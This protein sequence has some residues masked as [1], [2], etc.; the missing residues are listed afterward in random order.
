MIIDIF[1][2]GKFS[3]YGQ[4]VI[5]YFRGNVDLTEVTGAEKTE[6]IPINPMCAA[7]PTVVNCVSK[8]AGTT[9]AIDERSII[10]ILGQNVMN[11]KIYLV[12]W[13][14]FMVL[15]SV[16]GCMIVYRSLT[17]GIPSFQ[18]MTIQSFIKS[19]D[20]RAVQAL[21]LDYEHIGNWFVLGQIGRNSTPYNFRTFLDEI[22]GKKK[23]RKPE[24][25][26][27]TNV[28]KTEES[29]P[30][31]SY[32][33]LEDNETDGEFTKNIMDLEKGGFEKIEMK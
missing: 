7:F 3:S 4:D 18:R 24:K 28:E 33:K 12:L 2:S 23:A 26:E 10:C 16:S 6:R 22:V 5:S 19:R 14:W 32:K 21:K 1:L 13:F 11:Q 29:K 17:F 31:S 8:F 30:P 20:D 25:E 9:G 27:Q 15:F